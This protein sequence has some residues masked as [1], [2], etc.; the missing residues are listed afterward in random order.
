MILRPLSNASKAEILRNQA[1]NPL[2]SKHRP[3]IAPGVAN[4]PGTNRGT[5][6]QL[7]EVRRQ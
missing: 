3:Q 5:C 7:P 2:K 6:V 4:H 1:R